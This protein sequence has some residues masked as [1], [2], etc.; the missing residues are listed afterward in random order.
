MQKKIWQ[1]LIVII[2]CIA[3]YRLLINF[4]FNTL[5]KLSFKTIQLLFCITLAFLAVEILYLKFLFITTSLC[6][7]TRQLLFLYFASHMIGTFSTYYIG[8]ASFIIMLKKTAQTTY[9]HAASCSILDLSVR[10]SLRILLACAGTGLL[11]SGYY[12]W[13]IIVAV[14]IVFSFVI[15]TPNKLQN[16]LPQTEL[17]RRL[18][19]HVGDIKRTLMSYSRKKILLLF[20]FA[21]ISLLFESLVFLCIIYSFG[22]GYNI[23]LII[24]IRCLGLFISYC[25]FIPAFNIIEDLGV[26]GLW[27]LVGMDTN[28]AVAATAISRVF[29]TFLPLCMSLVVVTFFFDNYRTMVRATRK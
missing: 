9:Q 6:V 19:K 29:I 14:I 20:V 12:S 22:Y 11:L 17:M 10:Y 23:L 13:V 7:G 25:S 24:G 8:L 2:G 18:W 26:V 21:I 16:I 1:I 27:L 15:I 3:F 28:V 4:D 5:N